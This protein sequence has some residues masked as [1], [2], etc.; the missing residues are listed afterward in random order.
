[1]GVLQL[2][3]EVVPVGGDV[4]LAEQ[5]P[6]HHLRRGQALLALGLP[7]QLVDAV[8]LCLFHYTY[9]S[10][11]IMMR[12]FLEGP[13]TVLTA[14][15]PRPR[16]LSTSPSATGRSGLVHSRWLSWNFPEEISSAAL[17]R[18][19]EKPEAATASSRRELTVSRM[20]FTFTSGGSSLSRGRGAALSFARPAC[21]R[22]RSRKPEISSSARMSHA[23][24]PPARA[25][26]PV[27]PIRAPASV[28]AQEGRV[29]MR[30]PAPGAAGGGRGAAGR[31]GGPVRPRSPVG[32]EAAHRALG[33]L[34]PDVEQVGRMA[35]GDQQ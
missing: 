21:S 20:A 29:A 11:S 7:G 23:P 28:G 1:V 33:P 2:G 19:R 4:L 16:Q 30:G 22:G 8:D 27:R 31:S 34:V 3:D 13:P 9:R 25:G 18:D 10:S 14:H 5:I 32:R 24:S 6:L 35:G 15:L 17:P 12:P 26:A